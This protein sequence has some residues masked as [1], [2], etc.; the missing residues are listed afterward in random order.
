[1]K[2]EGSA[3]NV[4]RAIQVAADHAFTIFGGTRP[5]APKTFVLYVPS[6]A[7]EASN[8]IQAAATKLKS[9]GV[10]LMVV[11]LKEADE[12]LYRVASSQPS[13]KHF[14]YGS[15][16]DVH[17]QLFDAVDTICKGTLSIFS[18]IHVCS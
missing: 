7:P 5:T 4:A 2:K 8:A 10:K 9:I 16:D 15:Y 17:S 11:G 12:A 1:M 18:L 6:S 14:L 3:F 13:Q